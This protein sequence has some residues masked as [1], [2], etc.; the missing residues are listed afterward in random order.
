MESNDQLKEIDIKNRTCYYFHDVITIED[1]DINILIDEK[2]CE[3]ILVYN[4]LYKSLRDSK[5]F[6]KDSI[7]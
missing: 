6:Q 7:K 3:N 4:I 5:P 1:F 2:P